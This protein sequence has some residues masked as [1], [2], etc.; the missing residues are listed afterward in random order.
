MTEKRAAQIELLRRR[1]RV[2]LLAFV[3]WCWDRPFPFKV[4]RHTRA[5]CEWFNGAVERWKRGESSYCLFNT[6]PRHGKSDLCQFSEAFFLGV[7]AQ[8]H[9]STI[10]T[11]YGA[12]LVKNF[13]RRVMQLIESDAYRALF[14]G[15]C[16]ASDNASVDSWSL[17]GSTGVQTFVGLG[18]GLTGKGAHLAFVDDYCKSAEEADSETMREKT[19]EGFSSDLMTRQMPPAAIVVVTATPWHMDDLTCRIRKHVQDDP[20]FPRFDAL[21]YPAQTSDYDALFP[22]LYDVEWYDRQRATLGSVR[23][24]AM[25]L[26]NPI[27]DGVRLFKDEWLHTYTT[28]PETV[29]NFILVDT[30]GAKKRKNN[31]YLVMQVWGVANGNYYLLDLV[32]DKMNLSERT[33]RYKCLVQKWRPQATWWEQVG[34]QTD[35]DHV[36]ME[37]DRVGLHTP[38]YAFSQKVPKEGRIIWLQPLFEN[39]QVWLPDRII[40]QC[41]DGRVID[42]LAEWI[43]D[44]YKCYPSVS[45]DDGL[46]CMANL[47][48]P[49]IAPIIDNYLARSLNRGFATKNYAASRDKGIW[50]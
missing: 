20:Q 49:D 9:T 48:H 24:S 32:R 19:W 26:C 3:Q 39:A 38:M 30:A 21:C 7:T 15:V 43:E 28:R 11:G 18:G 10:Y 13:S 27:G 17:A 2:D 8:W 36:Q 16:L 25:F 4:G 31:D 37:L 47:R 23:W 14:P 12:G 41:S 33:E 5:Y 34:A 22:E 42:V 1:A 40:Q 46:D 6:P 44:E 45:H 35:M 50:L 29:A